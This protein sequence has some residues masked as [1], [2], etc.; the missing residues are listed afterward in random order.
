MQK[1]KRVRYEPIGL[2]LHSLIDWALAAL[3]LGGPFLMGYVHH[4]PQTLYALVMAAV[5]TG[6]FLITDYPGGLTKRMH[7]RWHQLFEILSPLA[8]MVGPWSL[9]GNHPAT[10][11]LSVIGFVLL[12]NTLSTRKVRVRG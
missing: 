6:L 11:L 12:V 9:F 1:T 5:L 2:G 10:W 4:L 8:F 3:C 7:M